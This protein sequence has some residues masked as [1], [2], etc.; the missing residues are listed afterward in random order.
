[1]KIKTANI[2][3]GGWLSMCSTSYA[4]NSIDPFASMIAVPDQTLASLRG[5]FTTQDGI[6]VSVGLEQ[7]TM[8]NGEIKTHLILDLTELDRVSENSHINIKDHGKFIQ[9]IQSGD[10]NAITTDATQL[11]SGVLTVIQNSK[12]MQQIQNITL[13]N[14]DVSNFSKFLRNSL[15]NALGESI[16]QESIRILR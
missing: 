15:S 11:S 12:D 9:L 8:I 13:V 3:I 6:D 5:G 16:N 7:L 14:V 10:H 1:M 4:S 2:L